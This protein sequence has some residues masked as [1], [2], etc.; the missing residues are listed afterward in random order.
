MLYLLFYVIAIIAVNLGFLLVPLVDLGFG[1]FSPMALFVGAIF[2]IRDFAQRAVGH[3]ILLG[4]IAGCIISFFLASPQI[5]VA[6]ALAFAV[7]ELVDWLVY[8]FTGKPFY[9]R[10]L[11]SSIVATPVDT[12]V[13]LM[14][15][16]MN[17]GPTFILMVCSKLVVAIGVYLYGSKNSSRSTN[18]V[19]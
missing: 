7:S 2:V 16:G 9:K 13:F 1:Y 10:V 12:G 3:L 11:I 4:M 14:A 18:P 6:S 15:I 5:A 17:S 19:S 8:T